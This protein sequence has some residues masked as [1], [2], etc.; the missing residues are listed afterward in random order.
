MAEERRALTM[1][2]EGHADEVG[3]L[4]RAFNLMV[5]A[6]RGSEAE[7]MR[8]SRRHEALLNSAG[9]GIYG[10]DQNGNCTFMNPAGAAM[11]GFDAADLIG[12]NPHFVFHHRHA[13]GTS[14][15]IEECPVMQT[16][17]DGA[18]RQV[19]EAYIAKSGEAFP[20]QMTIT[21]IQEDDKLAGAEVIFQNISARKAMEAELVRLATTD[22]LTGMANRRKFL[23]QFEIELARIKRFGRPA[24]FMMADIDHF[25][26][27]NDTHGHAVGDVVLKHFAALAQERLRR[28]DLIGRLGGE[29]FGILLPGTDMDGARLFADRMRQQV[30]DTPAGTDKGPI[31]ITVSIGIA[32][33]DADDP[34]PNS[35]LARADIALYRAKE[36]GRNRV[37]IN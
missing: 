27:V 33:F 24:T 17:Q 1:L 31:G 6:R 29:E 22:P 4:I 9:D 37:E 10:I 12:L 35:I 16:L 14:Y 2:P 25:K 3:R 8:L 19:E 36:G 15:P 32:E 18:S 23:E 34:D 13:D 11:L 21:P 30:A 26:N 20:V 7:A 5:A 28:V